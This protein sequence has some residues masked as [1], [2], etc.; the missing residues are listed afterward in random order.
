MEFGTRPDGTSMNW[1]LC[2]GGRV[3]G[4]VGREGECQARRSSD[5]S[6]LWV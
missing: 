6:G 2:L 1:S 5:Y 4:F 3:L